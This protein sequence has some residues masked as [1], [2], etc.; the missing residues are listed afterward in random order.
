M[1]YS[2]SAELKDG[3]VHV[4]IGGNSDV[5][6]TARYM[7]D[8]FRACREHKCTHLLIEENLKGERLSL[9][10]IFQLIAGKI[11]ELRLAIGVVAF[12]DA[13]AQH[14]GATL[15]FA[16]DVITNR[17]ITVRHFRTTGEAEAWLLGQITSSGP[18]S[19]S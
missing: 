17:G 8:M 3:Y 18:P 15:G 10:D 2:F 14:T 12:V 16:D 6:T 5:P 13:S 4:R 7:E 19:Q 9:G 11:D 1:D